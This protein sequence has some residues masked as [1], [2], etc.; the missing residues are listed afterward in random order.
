MDVEVGPD[1]GVY[2]L[3]LDEAGWF[4]GTGGGTTNGTLNRCDPEAG[5]CEVVTSDLVLPG[6]VAFDKWGGL[7]VV[8]SSLFATEILKIDA[9]P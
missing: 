4:A 7:W 3:E 1:G 8:N 5:T 6:A 2:V 9:M